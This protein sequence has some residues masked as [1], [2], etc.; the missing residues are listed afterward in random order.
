MQITKILSIRTIALAF[1]LLAMTFSVNAATPEITFISN[2]ATVG[3]ALGIGGTN[4]PSLSN[5]DIY[6]DGVV[7]NSYG[8][9]AYRPDGTVIVLNKFP[10]MTNGQ[11]SLFIKSGT[12]TSNT[13]KFTVQGGTDSLVQTNTTETSSAISRSGIPNYPQIEVA[14]LTISPKDNTTFTSPQ[15]L[16]V[17]IKSTSPTPIMKVE[18]YDN[19]T[20]AGT[21]YNAPFSTVWKISKDNNGRHTWV[22]FVYDNNGRVTYKA[23]LYIVQIDEQTSRTLIPDPIFSTTNLPTVVMNSVTGPSGEVTTNYHA[24]FNIAVVNS[25]S[26]IT[27]SNTGSRL[28]GQPFSFTVYKNGQALT[29]LPGSGET[30]PAGTMSYS[31]GNAITNSDGSYTIGSG[32][33]TDL[34]LHYFFSVTNQGGNRYGVALDKI[35]WY[36][37]Y[38]S[39]HSKD[40]AHSVGWGTQNT[41]LDLYGSNLYGSGSITTASKPV[42]VSP[43]PVFGQDLGMGNAGSDVVSLQNWLITHGFD[44]API[45]S[46]QQE[47]GYY[48]SATAQAVMQFQNKYQ[49]SPASGYF[50]MLTRTKLNSIS[51]TY[52]IPESA[53]VTVPAIPVQNITSY[54]PAPS[55]T[56]APAV[57]S[58][59]YP[60]TQTSP[61]M[62]ATPV[63]TAVPTPVATVVPTTLPTPL[64]TTAP[65]T[66]PTITALSPQGGESYKTSDSIPVRWTSSGYV[67]RQFNLVL[68]STSLPANYGVDAGSKLDFVDNTGAASMSLPSYVPPGQYVIRVMCYPYYACSWS[69]T[70]PFSIVQ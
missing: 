30:P 61:S 7:N 26:A 56:V 35:N 64:P 28:F 4:L 6:I 15:D 21:A 42:A 22:A 24:I 18:F 14:N 19:G 44:I 58:T 17:N 39:L 31:F 47:K 68:R 59:P 54:S 32:V 50:G 69:D 5:S 16:T 25:G 46:G 37:T 13:V 10:N 40:L 34:S 66:A 11:H 36:D 60:S 63:P 38:Q 2:P 70:K 12:A 49:I 55:N 9:G 67:T 52:S 41:P 51:C 65:V 48:G 8:G 1:V 57:S 3:Q 23:A 20:L 33:K 27:F 43:C 53:R 62:S 45:T 29:G